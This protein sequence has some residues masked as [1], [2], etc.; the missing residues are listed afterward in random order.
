MLG[1]I[2]YFAIKPRN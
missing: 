1:D 2:Q